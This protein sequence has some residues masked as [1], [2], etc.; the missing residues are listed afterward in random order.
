[1]NFIRSERHWRTPNFESHVSV[2]LQGMEDM[3]HYMFSNDVQIKSDGS[4]SD[5]ARSSIEEAAKD[6][7]YKL[8][9]NY[10]K[11]RF[12]QHP[13]DGKLYGFRFHDV[14]QK[15]SQHKFNHDGHTVHLTVN[16]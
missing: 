1:M 9:P 5:N 8:V 16:W 10:V 14:K 12:E 7:A 13:I 6:Y 15:S 11:I 2:T 3:G 4:L